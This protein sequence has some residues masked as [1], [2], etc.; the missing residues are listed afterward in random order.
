MLF[1]TRRLLKI[2]GFFFGAMSIVMLIVSFFAYVHTRRFVDIAARGEGT[3]IKLVETQNR[4]LR[5][6]VSSGLRLPRF[7]GTGTRNLLIRW[8]L[9][10]GLQGRREGK[11]VIQRRRARECCTRWIL[12]RL[13]HVTNLWH[14]RHSSGGRRPDLAFSCA[15]DLEAPAAVTVT[16]ANT[17]WKRW[18]EP[19]AQNGDAQNGTGLIICS[20]TA[21]PTSTTSLVDRRDPGQGRRKRGHHSY[22][23]PGKD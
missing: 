12:R 7:K 15:D 2:M 19:D 21:R 23:Q 13:A 10:S 14:D 20:A 22:W 1:G 16:N 4:E 17:G 18:G 11:C 5:H 3:V 8:Q 9:S 6:D